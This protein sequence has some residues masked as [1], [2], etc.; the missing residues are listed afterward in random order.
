MKRAGI[1]YTADVD[2]RRFDLL[3]QREQLPFPAKTPPTQYSLVEAFE[4]RL[5]LDL[6]EQGG[7]SIDVARDVVVGGVNAMLVHPLN[8]TAGEADL[9]AGVA[10]IRDPEM[11]EGPASWHSFAV[12]GTL[13]NLS[14]AAE[15]RT[16]EHGP[17]AQLVRLIAANASAAARFVRR[18]AHEMGLS[19]AQDFSRIVTQAAYRL[20][21]TKD[22]E[23]E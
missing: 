3:L 2:A 1:A 16:Q 15:A 21:Y 4:L 12:A 17:Q 14:A 10:M 22:R 23:G 11:G 7:V 19:E 20:E 13:A 9:W 8:Q 18:R 6:I 5:F